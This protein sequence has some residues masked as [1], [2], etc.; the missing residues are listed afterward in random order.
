MAREL[1]DEFGVLEPLQSQATIGLQVEELKNILQ[2]HATPPVYLVG[3]SWGGW[4]SLLF[5]SDHPTLVSK[6]ILVSCGALEPGYSYDMSASR[7]QRLKDEEREQL[8][9]VYQCLE[10]DSCTEASEAFVRFG[11][12]M[13]KLDSF[14]PVDSGS[15]DILEYQYPIYRSVWPEAMRMRE[16]GEL[17]RRVA[18]V[19]CPVVAIHGDYDPHPAAGVKEPLQRTLED[20]RFILLPQCGH[21][22]WQERQARE[23]F[24]RILRD[25]LRPG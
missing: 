9:Q 5:A 3:H 14:D 19:K 24:Y 21:T 6:L 7:L 8:Q 20:F 22:P 18:K 11:A 17:L 23:A 1:C 16:S 13:S 2:Q 15:T 25:E 12:L 10:D 4:L